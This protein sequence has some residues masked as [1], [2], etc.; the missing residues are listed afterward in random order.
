MYETSGLPA[1]SFANEDFLPVIDYVVVNQ[2][3]VNEYR[4]QLDGYKLRLVT[5]ADAS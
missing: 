5:L 4:E 1:R 3:R 2:A